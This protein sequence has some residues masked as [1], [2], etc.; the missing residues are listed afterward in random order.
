MK[1]SVALFAAMAVAVAGAAVAPQD[2]TFTCVWRG[3]NV[4]DAALPFPEGISFVPGAEYRAK[5]DSPARRHT[6]RKRRRRGRGS[7]RRAN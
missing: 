1:K 3:R 2:V 4:L 7:V 6:H 5:V